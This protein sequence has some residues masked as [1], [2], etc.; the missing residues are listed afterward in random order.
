MFI[1]FQTFKKAV[2]K[3]KKKKKAQSSTETY[4]ANQTHPPRGWLGKY[5]LSRYTHTLTSA[6]KLEKILLKP[7]SG[8]RVR[9]EKVG[10]RPVGNCPAPRLINYL[11][12]RVQASLVTVW[13]DKAGLD[14]VQVINGWWEN[15]L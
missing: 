11:E 1:L 4:T 8:H 7:R 3:L 5:L 14:Q 10:K 15:I 2:R 12:F 9:P 6:R 13:L